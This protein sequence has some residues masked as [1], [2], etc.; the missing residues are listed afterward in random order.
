MDILCEF[1]SGP[2]PF[3]LPEGAQ[4]GCCPQ[5]FAVQACRAFLFYLQL[6]SSSLLNVAHFSLSAI[7]VFKVH[8]MLG[9]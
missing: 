3:P 6:T 2:R 9:F 7:S 8:N 4:H 1:P 5:L